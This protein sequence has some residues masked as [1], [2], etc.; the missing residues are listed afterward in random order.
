MEEIIPSFDLR[1]LPI[2]GIFTLFFLFMSRWKKNFAI[3]H[4]KYSSLAQFS[5]KSLSWKALFAFSSERLFFAALF[6]LMLALFDPHYYL[7]RDRKEAPLPPKGRPKEGVAI[8]FLL[9]QSGSMA[10][11]VRGY[12]SAG[13]LSDIRK[14]DLMK[15]V[16]KEF[17]MGNQKKGLKGRPSDLIGVL[18]FARGAEVIAPLTLDH[19]AIIERLQQVDHVTERE[20]DGTSIGYAIF[21]A[22]NMI[23]A[24]RH[25]A[26]ELK[27]TEK[28]AYEVKSA[29]MVVVTDGFQSPSPLDQGNQWRNIGLVEAAD[30]AA[31]NQIRVYVVNV[32]PRLASQEFATQRKLMQQIAEMT[33][34]KFYLVDR[35]GGLD[36]IYAEI[37]R[38]EKSAIPEELQQLV[39]EKRFQP[40]KYRKFSLSPFLIGAALLLMALGIFL[41]TVVIRRIP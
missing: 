9:D 30:Y 35:P 5:Q 41:E 18:T 32:E 12:T 16:T 33:G 2:V 3:P 23:A 22:A 19:E 20:R 21:K 27:G 38:L 39:R 13:R 7:Q 25:F 10:K 24:T 28:P 37:D 4:I 31:K 8:Y 15:E 26:E 40:E 11:T 6:L 14:I 29:V 1:V 34:G 36:A 17:I